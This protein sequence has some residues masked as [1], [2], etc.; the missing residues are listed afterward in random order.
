MVITYCK[1][2]HN[3][4][5]FHKYNVTNDNCYYLKLTA[6]RKMWGWQLIRLEPSP[7]TVLAGL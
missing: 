3:E 5:T 2:Q 1:F 4:T 6:T 7:G